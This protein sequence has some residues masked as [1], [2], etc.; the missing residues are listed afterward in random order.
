M[1]SHDCVQ[2]DLDA[3]ALGFPLGQ[4]PYTAHRFLAG[5]PRLVKLAL[6]TPVPGQRVFQVG[7]TR[8]RKEIMARGLL[9]NWSSAQTETITRSVLH[10]AKQ[11]D[12]APRDDWFQRPQVVDSP[13]R[14]LERLIP[15]LTASKIREL[16]IP[17]RAIE[18]FLSDFNDR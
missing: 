15:H 13:H 2:H 12:L 4:V 18:S 16:Q 9:E 11:N 7:R 17:F 10:W 3:T 6:D 8:F 1:V 14:T 5:D